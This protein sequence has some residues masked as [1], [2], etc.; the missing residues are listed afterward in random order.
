MKT[1][2]KDKQIAILEQALKVFARGQLCP[3]WH[4]QINECKNCMQNKRQL[5]EECYENKIKFAK[6]KAE[7]E[8]KSEEAKKCP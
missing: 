3:R 1:T 2:E 5:A 6:E 7:K 4:E 8:I